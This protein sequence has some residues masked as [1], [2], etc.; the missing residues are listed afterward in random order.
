LE[1]SEC[2]SRAARRWPWG[3]GIGL[4]VVV[5]VNAVFAYLAVRGADHVVSSYRTERR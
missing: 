3:I 4:A 2:N 1:P 5:L